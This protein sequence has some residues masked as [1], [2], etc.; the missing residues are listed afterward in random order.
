MVFVVGGIVAIII[1]LKVAYKTSFG[2]FKG[3]FKRSW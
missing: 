2:E 3:K 1:C